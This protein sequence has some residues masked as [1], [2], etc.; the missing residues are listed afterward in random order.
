M[1]RKQRTSRTWAL[2]AAESNDGIRREMVEIGQELDEVSEGWLTAL[3]DFRNW[4]VRV[5]V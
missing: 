5:A 4:L 1:K 2:A 3:D